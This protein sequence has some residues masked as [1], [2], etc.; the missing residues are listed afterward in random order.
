MTE[1]KAR[2]VGSW[3]AQRPLA[4]RPR[5]SQHFSRPSW[6]TE[7]GALLDLLVVHQVIQD[8]SMAVD[9]RTRW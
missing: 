3:K 1:Y 7:S 5:W 8:D 4:W 9:L 6:A 2:P